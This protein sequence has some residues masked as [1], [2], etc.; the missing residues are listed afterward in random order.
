MWP[1]WSS[2]SVLSLDHMAT[3]Q[4]SPSLGR[5]IVKLG[6]SDFIGKV[7]TTADSGYLRLCLQY[8]F[9][10][11]TLSS[12]PYHLE[13]LWYSSLNGTPLGS[14][15]HSVLLFQEISC[16]GDLSVPIRDFGTVYGILPSLVKCAFCGFFSALR[17][18]YPR[19]H[20]VLQWHLSVPHTSSPLDG[21]YGSPVWRQ[22]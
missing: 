15:Y 13:N 14:S 2:A 8:L 19:R 4:C 6:D 20:I 12:T 5:Y 21:T 1:F 7:S 11:G 22:N 16:T 17:G 10:G 3:I 18:W 9:M